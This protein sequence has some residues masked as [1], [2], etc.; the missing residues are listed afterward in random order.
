MRARCDN[1]GCQPAAPRP[2]E[3]GARPHTGL[4]GRWQTVT[5]AGVVLDTLGGGRHADGVCI[6]RASAAQLVSEPGEGRRRCRAKSPKGTGRESR[7]PSRYGMCL[8]AGFRPRLLPYRLKQ[9]PDICFLGDQGKQGPTV[10][11]RA[12]WASTPPPKRPGEPLAAY[13]YGRRVTMDKRL[14]RSA[15]QSTPDDRCGIAAEGRRHG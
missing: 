13:P 8:P 4:D 15:R 3:S 10:A 9:A 2:L 14:C 5:D 1:P 7:S 6:W 11:E 12:G